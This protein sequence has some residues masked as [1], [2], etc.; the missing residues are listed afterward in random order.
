MLRIEK[1]YVLRSCP[2]RSNAETR[3]ILL[4]IL[5]YSTFASDVR[6]VDVNKDAQGK[7]AIFRVEQMHQKYARLLGTSSVP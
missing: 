1:E 6:R 2:L 4:L 7:G 5:C 3:S